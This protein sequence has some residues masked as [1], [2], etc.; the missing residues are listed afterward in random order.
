MGGRGESD[1]R[2]IRPVSVRGRAGVRYVDDN[3]PPVMREF[4]P[5]GMSVALTVGEAV[6]SKVREGDGL[7]K[8]RQ[9]VSAGQ[10]R[11][12]VLS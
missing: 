10:D 9:E 4:W 8:A 3:L 12:L 1:K 2:L 5:G 7:R 11:L 6:V